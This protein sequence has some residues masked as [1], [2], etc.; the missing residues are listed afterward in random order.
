MKQEASLTSSL[1]SRRRSTQNLVFSALVLAVL[2]P[3]EVVGLLTVVAVVLVHEISEVLRR[4]ERSP[5]RPWQSRN[6]VR[7]GGHGAS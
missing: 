3:S 6:R 7:L 2:T 4:R 5:H 1:S